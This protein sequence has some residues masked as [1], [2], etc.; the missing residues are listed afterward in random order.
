MPGETEKCPFCDSEVE[1]QRKN[2]AVDYVDCP[3]CGKYEIENILFAPR[4]WGTEKQR[5]RVSGVIKHNSNRGADPLL[6][7]TDNLKEIEALAPTGLEERARRLLFVIGERTSFF[8]QQVFLWPKKDYP[9]G[10]CQNR[11][12]FVSMVQLLA[13]RDLIT[14]DVNG[15]EDKFAIR[16]EAKGF[17]QIESSERSNLDSE[18]G[19]V[20]MWFGKEVDAAFSEGIKPAIEAAG[21]RPVRIDLVE[22]NK[23]IVF[24]VLAEVRR[25]R[26]MVSDF[27]AH[28]NGVYFES[29][30][31][32]GIGIPV[33]WTCRKDHADGA[34][35]D[36][37][38]FNHIRWETP[39][40]LK[41][42]LQRRIEATIGV[43]PL[44]PK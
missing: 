31:A 7:H 13:G 23:D 30:F 10:F 5:S 25:A 6:I 2:G 28:R 17:D 22:H 34:H 26:F 1:P 42:K 39:A 27:T 4:R 29:G 37:E 19:F 15:V 24:E 20:A 12:E 43:G 16:L 32:L 14:A 11:L 41:E 33:V 3:I 36:T 9:L 35:F 40:E 38:H 44:K 8:G 21:F 18:T